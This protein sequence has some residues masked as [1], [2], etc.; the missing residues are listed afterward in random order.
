VHYLGSLTPRLGDSEPLATARVDDGVLTGLQVELPPVYGPS[1]LW[2]EHAR[3]DT[4][5]FATGTSPT[6]WY[7]DPYVADVQRPENEEG[8]GAL[9]RSPLEEKQINVT[10]SR[11]GA[12]GRLVV[13]GVYAQGYTLSDVECADADGTPPCTTGDYDS[14][15]VF[16]FSRP[17]DE[18]GRELAPGS[19]VDRLTGSIG[20]FNGLTEVNFPQTFSTG[21]APDRDLLPAPTLIDPAWLATPIELERL[22]GG[23]VAIEGGVVCPLDDDYVTYG[24]WELDVGNGCSRP[25]DVVTRGQV[26]E[27]DPADYVGR[28]LPRVVGTLRPVFSYWIIYPRD[29]GDLTL[30][31][32]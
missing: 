13:T 17:A 3:G 21:D 22:E 12:R 5:T 9:E 1:F 28:P 20:E 8:V 15:F 29:A 25:F 32:A 16:S 19:T 23:L 30:P 27:F 24:Q 18:E 2:L 11:H 14:I 26:G 31:D 7:R 4:P 6:L 10:E